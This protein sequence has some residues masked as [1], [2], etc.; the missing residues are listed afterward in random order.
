ML[1]F[2]PGRVYRKSKRW[3]ALRKI[4]S[5]SA[6]A[7]VLY[8]ACY[9]SERPDF[10]DTVAIDGLAIQ[11]ADGDS[12]AIGG[13]KLRLKGIDAP[14]YQQNCKDAADADWPCG[15]EAR[16][17]LQK[18]LTEPG[19]SC[20][21]EAK[22]R[23]GRNLAICRTTAIADLAAAQVKAGMAVSDEY[24]GIRS[25]GREEDAARAAKRG[26]WQGAFLRPAEYRSRQKD[27]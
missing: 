11:V 27:R 8:S 25:F 17:A 1:K 12:F 4:L 15:R 16:T 22:D 18:L 13:R 23:Y 6:L 10:Y 21:A 26:L 7:V 2:P 19:L 24:N 3:R 9:F 20:A 14:E 5:F